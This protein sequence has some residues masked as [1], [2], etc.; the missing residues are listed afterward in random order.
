MHKL[1]AVV[2]AVLTFVSCSSGDDDAASPTTTAPTP[3]QASAAPPPSNQAGN[4]FA[5]IPDLVERVQPSVVSVLTDAGS[6]SGVVY[7]DDGVI[8]TNNHVI[9]R[10]RSIEVAFADG[11]R[12]EAELLATDDIVDLAVLKV[13]GRQVPPAAFADKLPR[14][15]ELA[16]ALGDPLGFENSVTVGVVSGLHRSIPGSASQSASLVD[17]IQ[18]DAPISPG[19][20]GG[21]LVGAAGTVIGINVAYL[22]PSTGS[23]SLGFAIPAATVTQTVDQLLRTGRA[24]HA[25]LG[26]RPT[27]LTPELAQQFGLSA[28]AGVLVL[29]VEQGGPAADAGM[30]PGDVLSS[31]DGRE[32]RTAEDLLAALRTR[33]PGDTVTIEAVRGTDRIEQ[34]AQLSNRPT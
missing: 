7:R 17:L 25:F 19:N 1:L 2:V 26:I 4:P 11:Q 31:I 12:A 33:K 23:V 29:T 28:T 18:T 9:A 27:T 20:S 8:V 34:R 6:G 30:R 10:A 13:E 5:G 16:I 21:A 22:P 24:E 15:G 32:L 3:A 14:V